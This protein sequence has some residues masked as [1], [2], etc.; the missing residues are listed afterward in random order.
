MTQYDAGPGDRSD[1]EWE[2]PD[3]K[4]TRHAKRRGP[5]LPPWALMAIV[6]GIVIV[7]C[8]ALIL[9]V[10]AIRGAGADETSTPRP[11]ATRLAVPIATWT[12]TAVLTQTLT[13]TVVLPL[14]PTGQA[15][16]F[17]EIAPG[18]TVLIQG[19]AAKGLNLRAQPTTK[20]AIVVTVK[21]GDALTVVEGPQ[22][23]DG[24]TWWKLR[25]TDNKEGW[26]AADWLVLK[27]SQ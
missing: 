12:P 15:Q 16:Q 21:E 3:R 19:T 25:T 20:G 8:V 10:R 24:F 14:G 9:V 6:V 4:P 23:A 5:T 2:S 1:R 11:T 27:P 26:G 13:P 17:T 7:L 22:Q 18:A